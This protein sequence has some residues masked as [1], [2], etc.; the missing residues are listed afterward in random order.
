M[1]LA[2]EIKVSVTAGICVLTLAII[3]KYFLDIELDF[4]SQYGPVWIFITY[5]LTRNKQGKSR[6]CNRPLF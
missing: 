6:I 1:T 3:S 2:S 4:V 5:V